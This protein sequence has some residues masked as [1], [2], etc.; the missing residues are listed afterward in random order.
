MFSNVYAK[1]I[2]DVLA[3]LIGPLMAQS[4]LRLLTKRMNMTPED[5]DHLHL[6]VIA[7]EIER[8]IRIFIGSDKAREVAQIIESLTDR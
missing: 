3:P 2:C 4:S 5:I 8:N 1:K 6:A 7:R